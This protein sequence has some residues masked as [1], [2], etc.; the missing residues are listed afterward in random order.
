MCDRSNVKGIGPGMKAFSDR[1]SRRRYNKAIESRLLTALSMNGRISFNFLSDLVGIEHQPV[2]RRIK[3][4][5]K[6]Y[7]IKY[8]AEIDVEMLGYLKF[9]ILV[10]FEKKMP[11]EDEIVAAV[12]N[13][14]KVQL[15]ALLRGGAY[16]LLIYALAENNT[17]IQDVRHNLV[18]TG[19]DKYDAKW[20]IVPFTETYNFVPL[21][22]DFMDTLES[23]VLKRYEIKSTISSGKRK[24][25]LR[26]E[27][28]VLKELNLDGKIQFKDIDSKYGF[29]IGRAQYAYHKLLEA[30]LLKRVTIT[31]QNPQMKYVGAIFAIVTNHKKFAKSREKLLKNI[32]EDSELP[33]SKYLLVGDIGEPYGFVFFVPVF[34]DGG[35]EEAAGKLS[36]MKGVEITASVVTKMLY[37]S[38]CCRRFDKMYSQ[39]YGVLVKNYKMNP[40]EQIKYNEIKTQEK[41]EETIIDLIGRN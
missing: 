27:F 15:A 23:K 9:L 16:D 21:R 28:A 4:L 8:T 33:S 26:R 13:E 40:S 34:E 6:R 30:G 11:E 19:L 17:D 31:M 41:E 29:D 7:K 38:L 20:Y 37:G 39:Q 22:N 3:I 25:I 32:I 18:K 10:K 5:E 36:N 2:Y 14:P 24:Q 12:A 35:L 1:R